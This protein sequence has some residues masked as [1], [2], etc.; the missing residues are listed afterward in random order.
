[1]QAAS[2][3]SYAISTIG[4]NFQPSHVVNHGRNCTIE[5]E[6]YRSPQY[7]PM[8]PESEASTNRGGLETGRLFSM[9]LKWSP[10][11]RDISSRHTCRH[12]VIISDSGRMACGKLGRIYADRKVNNGRPNG[13][14]Q[15]ANSSL[16]TIRSRSFDVAHPWQMMATI[17]AEYFCTFL[18]ASE[19]I[20]RSER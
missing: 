13:S 1:M 16:P 17:C 15:A 3:S 20:R 11:F 8:P 5:S 9:K 10:L 19:Q 4:N 14:T 12:I 7:P 6:K 2:S 18:G